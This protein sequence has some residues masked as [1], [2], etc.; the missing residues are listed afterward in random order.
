[1]YGG[2]ADKPQFFGTALAEVTSANV[3]IAGSWNNDGADAV[4][5]SRPWS[6]FGGRSYDGA[7]N[8]AFSSYNHTGDEDSFFSHR[9][10]LSG[11]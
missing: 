1:M 2:L 8:G 3:S 6:G 5:S 9:T 11:Y 10:I 4:L 7:R